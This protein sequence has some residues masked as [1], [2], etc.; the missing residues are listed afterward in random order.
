MRTDLREPAPRSPAALGPVVAAVRS[1]GWSH[2]P[3]FA[4]ADDDRSIAV[5]ARI[6]DGIHR[7]TLRQTAGGVRIDVQTELGSTP[8]PAALRQVAAD[9]LGLNPALTPFWERCAA[10][11]SHAWAATLGIGNQLRMP[12]LYEDLLVLLFSTNCAFSR[13]VTLVET[14]SALTDDAPPSDLPL[15]PRPSAI[16][17][18]G[19]PGLRAAGLGFRAPFVLALAETAAAG[20]LPERADLLALDAEAARAALLELS[21]VGPY[22]AETAL[23]ISGVQEFYGIDSWNRTKVKAAAKGPAGLDRVYRRRFGEWRGL[24]YW[25]DAT[26]DW[27]A[28]ENGAR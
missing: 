27:Y 25:I 1:H 11:E 8:A 16:L 28:A 9:V 19:E 5:R 7:L 2:L 18:A 6:G 14:V 21:G 15:L 12:S 4:V 13:V 10:S 20:K 23:R 17:A 22:V 3:L 24:A 26:R